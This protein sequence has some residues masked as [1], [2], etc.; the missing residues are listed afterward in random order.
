MRSGAPASSGASVRP[1]ALVIVSFRTPS[2]LAPSSF[3]TTLTPAAGLPDTVSSTW[4]ENRPS[5]FGL[6]GPS[7]A[8]TSR[9]RVMWPISCERGRPLGLGAV[10]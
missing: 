7:T 6:P 4:V 3:S 10:G 5:V 2:A 8:S 9:S 1:S